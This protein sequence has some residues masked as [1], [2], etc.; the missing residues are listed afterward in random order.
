MGVARMMAGAAGK[1]MWGGVGCG[2]SVPVLVHG[3]RPEHDLQPY[4]RFLEEQLYQRRVAAD[5]G[6]EHVAVDLEVHQTCDVRAVGEEGDVSGHRSGVC[7]P[8]SAEQWVLPGTA[9]AMMQTCVVCEASVRKRFTFDP[10][11]VTLEASSPLGHVLLSD[12]HH[13]FLGRQ[14]ALLRIEG[15]SSE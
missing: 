9:H 12:L 2:R 10:E 13:L 11:R 8:S 4:R 5:P 15:W 1:A 14:C 7:L 6:C 3:E